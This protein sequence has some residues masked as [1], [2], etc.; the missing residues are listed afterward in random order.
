MDRRSART[1]QAQTS[2]NVTYVNV[3][4]GYHYCRI[5]Q[6][7]SVC[8]PLAPSHQPLILAAPAKLTRAAPG[9]RHVG[10][11]ASC[12]EKVGAGRKKIAIFRRTDAN[13]RPKI[14][15]VLK[16]LILLLN[17][18]KTLE[19]APNL[20]FRKFS[21]RIKFS[22]WPKFMGYCPSVPL[23]EHHCVDALG[24]I[25]NRGDPLPSKCENSIFAVIH[26][27]LVTVSFLCISESNF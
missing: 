9:S 14:Y 1:N 20:A 19:K 26:V 3:Q 23:P 17:V 24:T 15:R 13:F 22:H 5:S 21:T 27:I 18:L 7:S 11:E 8:H 10:A 16:I 4:P 2:A 25:S 12:V 6:H